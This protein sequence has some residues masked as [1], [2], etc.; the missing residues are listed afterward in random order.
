MIDQIAA[1]YRITG[2][3]KSVEVLARKLIYEQTVEL[4]PELIAPRLRAE[5]V[6]Q[7]ISN[8]V[9]PD[10]D[11]ARLVQVLYRPYLASSQ[12]SQLFNLLYGNISMYSGVRLVQLILP[13]YLVDCFSGPQYGIDGLRSLTGVYNR[14]LLATALKPRGLSVQQL[15]K[16][17]SDF[18]EAGGDLVKDDQNLVDLTLDEFKSR[19]DEC[20]S[21]VEH[22]NQST[23][24]NCLY[25]PH[26]AGPDEL[27]DE[28]AR[29]V[30]MRG[31]HGVLICPL[32]IGLDRARALANRYNLVFMAHPALTGALTN[33]T[34]EGIAPEVLLG[35]LFRLAGADISIFTSPGGRFDVNQA[36][37]KA[38]A[39][40]LRGNFGNVKTAFP[41][42]AGGIQLDNVE[43]SFKEYGA[44]TV[45]LIGGGLQAHPEG[46]G[47]GTKRFL[48]AI[49]GT[50]E[51]SRV[52]P[53]S[54]HSFSCDLP[55]AQT[56][57]QQELL[58]HNRD[59]SW[60]GRPSQQYKPDQT[61][62]FKGVS[63][64]ELIGK[65][66]EEC[67]FDLRYFELEPEGYT[68]WEKH[69]HIHVIIGVRGCGVL[70][71]EDH[72]VSIKPNDIA[73]ISPLKAH[74][75][76]NEMSGHFGFYCIVDRQRDR[77][78]QVQRPK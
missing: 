40:A 14:P 41:S 31:L 26:L 47:G 6:G 5:V 61:L 25:F 49:A 19:V 12:I 13:E 53:Q 27:L 37:P 74:Q 68:S 42:P 33:G 44:D 52:S 51:G 62:P 43:D 38:I 46:I 65:Q 24:K 58:V 9:D 48:K 32:L 73:Y 72:S 4:P 77:P 70:R 50:Y 15:A 63:R 23:G 76:R 22:A 1:T 11:R 78:M 17:A 28:M 75:L 54:N 34:R 60:N 57:R 45:Y 3:A 39:K 66:G 10:H 64:T 35:T 59:F 30:R 29:F 21:A 36:I 69:I 55:S 7:V 56:A 20:A 67:K 18:A 2:D 8:E 71:F 16:L